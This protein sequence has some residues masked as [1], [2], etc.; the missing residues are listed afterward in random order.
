M[1]SIVT[2]FEK[3]NFLNMVAPV[4]LVLLAHDLIIVAMNEVRFMITLEPVAPD[5]KT[6][7]FMV[8]GNSYSGA[9]FK[10]WKAKHDLIVA[11][12]SELKA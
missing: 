9:L 5:Q 10:R 4:T 7:I 11:M 8:A 6:Y 3:L 1:N 12:R 2:L